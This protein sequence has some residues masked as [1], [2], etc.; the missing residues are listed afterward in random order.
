MS[1]CSVAG[2]S[3]ASA[4]GATDKL[5]SSA[6]RLASAG[7][8]AGWAMSMLDAACFATNASSTAQSLG[9]SYWVEQIA[10]GLSFPSGM[11][12]LPTGE[13]LI[14]ERIGGLRILRDGQLDP[15][16][17][18]GAPVYYQSALDG[19]RDIAVDPRSSSRATIYL[20]LSQGTFEQRHAVV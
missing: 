11:A 16:P 4:V 20:L 18:R 6:K 12:W 14:T 7:V 3:G 8:I 2:D 19:L 1:V 15:Q 10:E 9:Q 13:L 5:G 17:V